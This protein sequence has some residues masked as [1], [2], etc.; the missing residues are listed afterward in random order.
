MNKSRKLLIGIVVL[1][2]I[3]GGCVVLWYLP[4]IGTSP[5]IPQGSCAVSAL[6]LGESEFPPGTRMSSGAGLDHNALDRASHTFANEAGP[7]EVY[8]AAEYYNTQFLAWS[9]YEY[10]TGIFKE[11]A[12][13]SRWSQWDGIA[14]SSSLANQSR[15]A[16]SSRFCAWQPVRN[17]S[18][19]RTVYC[20]LPGQSVRWI[21]GS[22]H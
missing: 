8:H 11:S 17:D 12:T 4:R 20:V 18:S 14:F 2:L 19:V 9:A 5:G 21:H 1:A 22:G 13:N 7:L 16:C 15:F 10:W 3:F 6:L